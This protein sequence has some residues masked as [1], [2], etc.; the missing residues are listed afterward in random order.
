M[1]KKFICAMLMGVML[2]SGTV[3]V[4]AATE[5]TNAQVKTEDNKDVDSKEVTYTI[6]GIKFQDKNGTPISTNNTVLSVR[7]PSVDHSLLFYEIPFSV[8]VEEGKGYN[9]KVG[10]GIRERV[11]FSLIHTDI[12]NGELSFTYDG[13]WGEFCT[14]YKL[15]PRT[16]KLFEEEGITSSEEQAK[17]LNNYFKG[18]VTPP[19]DKNDKDEPV[20]NK[21]KDVPSDNKDKGKKDDSIDNKSSESTPSKT[22]QSTDNNNKSADKKVTETKKDAVKNTVKTGDVASV[23]TLVVAMLGSAVASLKTKK[24]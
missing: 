5:I 4:K 3:T 2:V 1:K 20:D 7:K 13:D 8:T 17:I 16:N 12:K 18:I 19:T 21:D 23:G 24:H 14:K 22:A 15:D 9:Y 11:P 6:T 10:I